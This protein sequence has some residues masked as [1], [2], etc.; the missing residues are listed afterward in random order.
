VEDLPSCLVA[1][2]RVVCFLATE[3]PRACHKYCTY[4]GTLDTI[5]LLALSN[6]HSYPWENYIAGEIEDCLAEGR[7]RGPA[8]VAAD[9]NVYSVRR[10]YF[11]SY[12]VQA[13]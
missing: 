7:G 11:F 13:K 5:T 2:V 3:P 4:R 9:L 8:M 12:G 1:C 10:E 6:V